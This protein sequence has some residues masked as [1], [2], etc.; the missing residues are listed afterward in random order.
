ML[1]S[2]LFVCLLA[3]FACLGVG[4]RASNSTRLNFGF[5]EEIKLEV[6]TK[7]S[8]R[9]ATEYVNQQTP[10]THDVY[11]VNRTKHINGRVTL[12]SIE[13]PDIFTKGTKL[14][15]VPIFHWN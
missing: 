7:N 4:D 2:Y 5:P 1:C 11:T 6:R 13:S 3:V 14:V 15:G 8:Q 10:K 12:L 9:R